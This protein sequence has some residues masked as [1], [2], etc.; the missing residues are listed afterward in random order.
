MATL[1]D[2]TFQRDSLLQMLREQF[3]NAYVLSIEQALSI[4]PGVSA[5]KTAAQKRKERGTYPFPIRSKAGQHFVLL[6]DI[7]TTLA[8]APV[9]GD[10]RFDGAASDQIQPAPT[11]RRGP[12][13]PRKSLEVGGAV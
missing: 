1:P 10:V 7:A 3:D 11:L 2:Y 9:L 8:A 12:G 13:R 5:S 6:A 4:I